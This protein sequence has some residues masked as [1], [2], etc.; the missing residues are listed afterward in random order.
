M[1]LGGGGDS[2]AR[3]RKGEHRPRSWRVRVGGSRIARRRGGR[4]A[5]A[6]AARKRGRQDGEEREKGRGPAGRGAVRGGRGGI[7]CRTAV[8]RGAAQVLP[9]RGGNGRKGKK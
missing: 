5:P 3:G 9:A 6:S 7:S 4:G 2:N 1:A 8:G